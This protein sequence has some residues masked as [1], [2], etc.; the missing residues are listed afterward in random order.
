MDEVTGIWPASWENKTKSLNLTLSTVNYIKKNHGADQFVIM[1]PGDLFDP[2]ILLNYDVTVKA[3]VFESELSEWYPKCA[4]NSKG[5][6]FGVGPFCP[7]KPTDDGVGD[8]RVANPPKKILDYIRGGTIKPNQVVAMIKNSKTL[9]DTQINDI[10]KGGLKSNVGYIYLTD[11]G[12]NWDTLPS[13]KLWNTSTTY[14]S[15][16]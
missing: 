12:G 6:S 1:N 10:L 13:S 15:K 11:K 2:K 16:Y 7:F 8:L 9:N 4:K 14:L 3:I 5:E